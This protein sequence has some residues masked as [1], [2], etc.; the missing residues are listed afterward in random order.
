MAFSRKIGQLQRKVICVIST[1]V[2]E[3]YANRISDHASG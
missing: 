1:K 2:S 3:D